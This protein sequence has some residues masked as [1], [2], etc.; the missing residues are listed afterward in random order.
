MNARRERH[1]LLVFVTVIIHVSFSFSFP[2]SD[3]T[4]TV[5]SGTLNPSIPYFVFFK[6]VLVFISLVWHHFYFYI[7][8][9]VLKINIVF[10]NDGQSIFDFVIVAVT[11]I[12]L[13][14]SRQQ[15][16]GTGQTDGQTDK[17]HQCIML[18]WGRGI[19]NRSAWLRLAG[20]VTVTLMTFDKQSNGRRI[21][22]KS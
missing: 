9:F 18:P 1:E 11:E 15:L 16:A 4:Y 21:E 17:D 22:V 7:I 3:M 14:R 8:I 10:V 2:V 12:S 20:Y 19:I 5:S 6:N 13:F